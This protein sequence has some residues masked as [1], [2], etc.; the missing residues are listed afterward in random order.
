MS[1]AARDAYD[2]LASA[3]WDMDRSV[4]SGA[5]AEHELAWQPAPRQ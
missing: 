5:A 2:A 4:G 1:D 3:Q